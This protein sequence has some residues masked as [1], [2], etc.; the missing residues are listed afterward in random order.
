MGPLGRSGYRMS[1]GSCHW[2]V[3]LAMDAYVQE[4]AAPANATYLVNEDTDAR[5]TGIFALASE[6]RPLPGKD[7]IMAVTGCFSLGI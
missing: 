3:P 4:L 6:P 1:N 7:S 2:R 5:L